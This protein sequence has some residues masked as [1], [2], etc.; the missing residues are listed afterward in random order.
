MNET[1][2]TERLRLRKALINKTDYPAF[3][4]LMSDWNSHRELFF[5]L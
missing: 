5:S 1:I 3:R 2:E 4:Q